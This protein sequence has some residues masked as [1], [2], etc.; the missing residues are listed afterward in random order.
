MILVIDK[1]Q[2]FCQNLS[3]QSSINLLT[4]LISDALK[5]KQ[6][7]CT[8]S[9]STKYSPH[10]YRGRCMLSR[11]ATQSFHGRDQWL[12]KNKQDFHDLI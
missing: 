7:Y 4:H 12:H 6:V 5:S 3:Q 9:Q 2:L 1:I 10:I 8:S 11:R